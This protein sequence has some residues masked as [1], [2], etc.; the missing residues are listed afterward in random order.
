LYLSAG[1]DQRFRRFRDNA[2]RKRGLR[3]RTRK[4]RR[5]R[6]DR[7]RFGNEYRGV[8]GLRELR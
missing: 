4:G 6:R 3:L 7:R 1:R 5:R 8:D 2:R